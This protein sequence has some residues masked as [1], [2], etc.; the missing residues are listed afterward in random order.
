MF[1]EDPGAICTLGKAS[2]LFQLGL[3]S[4]N[5]CIASSNKCLTSSNKKLLVLFVTQAIFVV[6]QCSPS[7]SAF[8][9]MWLETLKRVV[10]TLLGFTC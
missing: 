9:S 6:S 8:N 3:A 5:K 7:L 4:S 2:A 10:W 1:Q